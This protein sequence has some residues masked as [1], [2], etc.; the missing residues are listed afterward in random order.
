MLSTATWSAFKEKAVSADQW[1]APEKLQA[2]KA[3]S[4]G[5]GKRLYVNI[6]CLDFGCEKK[7]W[8]ILCCPGKVERL[9][10]TQ[11]EPCR[12][13]RETYN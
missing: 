7:I 12:D 6:E 4:H 2:R 13:M 9:P 3:A 8:I 11:P 10:E 5:G 1:Y